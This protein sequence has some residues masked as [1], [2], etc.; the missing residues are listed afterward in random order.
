MY[1][2]Q[3]GYIDTLDSWL[4]TSGLVL[5]V[6]PDCCDKF[7][8]VSLSFGSFQCFNATVAVA[9]SEVSIPGLYPLAICYIAIENDHR[10]SGFT[11]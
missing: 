3:A 10:N 4:K 5:E 6:S 7:R 2:Y 9:F 11:H 8:G 1:V